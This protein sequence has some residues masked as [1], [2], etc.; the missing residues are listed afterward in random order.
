MNNIFHKNKRLVLIF[1]ALFLALFFLFTFIVK[2][3]ILNN[4]D[5]DATARIQRF[6]P[7]AVDTFLSFFS[8]LGSFEITFLF[9]VFLLISRKKKM[10]F[11]V[12]GI[13]FAAHVVEIFGKAFLEQPGPPIQ[14]FRY[15][16]PFL[17]LSTYVQPG[18]SYPSGH[19]LRMVFVF[20]IALGS[21]YLSK[22]PAI[23]TKYVLYGILSLI[24]LIMIY[25]RV[26]LGEHWST[27]VIGG[28]FLGISAG[29]FSILFL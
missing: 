20:I 2:T 14:F 1:S 25:S 19:A 29:I 15:N 7:R 17:F 27:D 10:V 4:F 23:R 28:M 24:A 5:F 3:D 12:V 9:L 6:T 11:F 21:I 26:S 18:S 22:R 16:L 8:L 13:F